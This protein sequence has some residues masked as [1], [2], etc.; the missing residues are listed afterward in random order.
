[1]EGLGL[2][3]VSGGELYTARQSGFPMQR[4]YVHG[5]NKSDDELFLALEAGVH[6]VVID[7][8]EEVGR[9]SGLGAERSKNQQGLLRM[10]PG[11]EGHTHA[12]VLTGA[13]DTKFGVS[14]DSGAARQVAEAIHNA[15][16]L[17][18]VGLHAHIGSQIFELEPYQATVRRVFELAAELREAIGFELKELSPGG[19]FSIQYT[20]EDEPPLTPAQA[21][22]AIAEAVTREAR[23]GGVQPPEVTSEPGRSTS[24]PSAVA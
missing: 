15:D 11:V 9:L 8:V 21:T 2:D 24:G 6:R 3:V 12:H 7:N 22:R 14:I 19:G 16:S 1:E 10:A 4:I 23:R 18:L 20:A 5:N 17:E 13:S